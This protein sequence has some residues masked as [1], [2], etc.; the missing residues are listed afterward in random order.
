MAIYASAFG[1]IHGPMDPGLV[2]SNWDVEGYWTVNQKIETVQRPNFLNALSGTVA[3]Y[4]YSDVPDT[5]R[6][7]VYGNETSNPVH[8][9]NTPMAQS[10][11]CIGTAAAVLRD[12]GYYHA[13][14]MWSLHN[15]LAPIESNGG[16]WQAWFLGIERMY[17][18]SNDNSFSVDIWPI[19][20]MS[21][22]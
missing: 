10:T 13:A 4:A 15:A 20:R 9:A 2:R 12:D 1:E 16:F 17:G 19:C 5:F 8:A 6:V 22:S 18:T 7:V 21:A 3:F 14:G 11:F